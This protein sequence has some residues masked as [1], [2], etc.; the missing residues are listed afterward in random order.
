MHLISLDP[1]ARPQEDCAVEVSI[2]GQAVCSDPTDPAR[3]VLSGFYTSPT[4]ISSALGAESGSLFCI[5]PG[6]SG[7]LSLTVFTATMDP[8]HQADAG[9]TCSGALAVTGAAVAGAA[10]AAC[11]AG[12]LRTGAGDSFS[13]EPCAPGQYCPAPDAAAGADCGGGTASALLGL[14]APVGCVDCGAGAYAAAGSNF[15][16]LCAAGSYS[17]SVAATACAPCGT[18]AEEGATTCALGGACAAGQQHNAVSGECEACDPGW[19]SDGSG[20][21]TACQAGEEQNVDQSACTACAVGYFAAEAGTAACEAC[22]AGSKRAADD[23]D[24][25]TCVSCSAGYVSNA[26]SASTSCTACGANTYRA[27]TASP[28]S[29]RCA[30]CPAGYSTDAATASASCTKCNKGTYRASAQL[31]SNVCNA[32]PSGTIAARNAST[33]CTACRGGTAP[34]SDAT[35]CVSCAIATFRSFFSAS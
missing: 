23:A 27:G 8:A 31:P 11:P 13:C 34:N 26:A 15:C 4:T 3:P 14:D 32:C 35:A 25:T 29:N 30:V 2:L 18:A 9:T 33:A 7:A 19:V 12:T 10:G 5:A 21:C 22:P 6:D 24:A 1:P 20:A 17:D 28:S 16:T